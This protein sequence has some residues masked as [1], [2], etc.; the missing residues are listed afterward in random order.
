M[1]DEGKIKFYGSKFCGH[2]RVAKNYLS[3]NEIEFEYLDVNE[4][5][6]AEQAVK[7]LNNGNRSVPTLVFP[8]GTVLTEP[9]N[10]EIGKK[11][12]EG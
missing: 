4:D 12:G 7:D 10:A 3:R 2:S 11:L 8:D 6:D 5:P 1:S 9:S